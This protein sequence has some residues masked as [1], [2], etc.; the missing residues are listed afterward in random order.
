MKIEIGCLAQIKWSPLASG[1][2]HF[3][4][5]QTL[6]RIVKIAARG[7]SDDGTHPIWI[8]EE[9]LPIVL[10]GKEVVLR[11]IYEAFLQPILP[12]GLVD[13]VT[14]DQPIEAEVQ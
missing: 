10:W 1:I 4:V 14:A 12:P 9:P 2:D 11:G 5:Q 13:E 3:A 6:G 8:F 7:A